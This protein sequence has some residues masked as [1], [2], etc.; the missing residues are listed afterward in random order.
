MDPVRVM[1]AMQYTVGAVVLLLLVANV[2]NIFAK[3][4]L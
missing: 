2:I 4:M 1:N 3:V